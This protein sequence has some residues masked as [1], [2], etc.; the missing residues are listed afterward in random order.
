MGRPWSLRQIQLVVRHQCLTASPNHATLIAEERNVAELPNYVVTGMRGLKLEL[1]GPC[2]A[3][4][5]ASHSGAE[6]A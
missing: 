6:C 3:A 1:S 2:D 4:A 5:A